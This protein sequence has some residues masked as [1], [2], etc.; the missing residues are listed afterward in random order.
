MKSDE[1]TMIRDLSRYLRGMRKSLLDK[2]FFVDKIFEPVEGIVDFGCAGGDLIKAL[3]VF[4][5]DYR[6]IGYDLSE[7]M[8]RTARQTVPAAS[9]YSRWDDIDC[10]FENCLLNLSSVTHEVYAYGTAS[11]VREYWDRVF[12][13]GFR[14]ISIRDMMLSDEN[15]RPADPRWLDAVRAAEP[16]A[17]HLADFEE[18]NGPIESEYELVHYLLKY[19]Y[20]QNWEREVREN[21]L[22]ITRETMLSLIPEEYEVVYDFHEVYPFLHYRIKKDFGFTLTEPTHQKLILQRR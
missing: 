12:Q 20:T 19:R 13:S 9:F 16:F 14:Y 21:Y 10:D 5:A 17:G 15:R 1:Q 8:I 11:D 3:Q 18:V 6:Y 4:Y 2:M 7:D 22:P